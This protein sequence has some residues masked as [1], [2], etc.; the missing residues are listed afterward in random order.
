MKYEV[1]V[2]ATDWCGYCET[3]IVKA[4]D[5]EQAAE[6]G[7]QEFIQYWELLME[8]ESGQYGDPDDFDE[9]GEP[10]EDDILTGIT[11]ENVEE[12]E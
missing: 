7:E 8:A 1:T 12:V 10:L 2:S 9:N 6:L 3:F 11:V 4:D 5:K